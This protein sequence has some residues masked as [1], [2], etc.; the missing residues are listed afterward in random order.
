MGKVLIAPTEGGTPQEFA[1]WGSLCEQ[2]QQIEDGD[3]PGNYT[4]AKDGKRYLFSP[5]PGEPEGDP[6]AE[7]E[8]KSPGPDAE[9][10]SETQAEP[11]G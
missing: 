1:V 9:A 4:V 6:L 8:A 5:A 10:A 7:A 11:T 3:V 2:I